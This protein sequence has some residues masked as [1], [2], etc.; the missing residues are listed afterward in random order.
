MYQT[1]L[2]PAHHPLPTMNLE[3]EPT[4]SRFKR[5]SSCSLQNDYELSAGMERSCSH[6]TKR[7]RI[8]ENAHLELIPSMVTPSSSPMRPGQAWCHQDQSQLNSYFHPLPSQSFSF[9][10]FHQANICIGR[11]ITGLN[12]LGAVAPLRRAR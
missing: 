10:N 3:G 9:P 12:C 5:K 11:N 1:V 2:S 6:D 4:A 7:R 8:P